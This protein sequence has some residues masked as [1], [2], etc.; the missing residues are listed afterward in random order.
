[1]TQ[2]P[3][4]GDTRALQAVAAQYFVNG[5]VVASY[6]PRLPEIR[7][8]LDVSLATIGL[9]ITAASLGGL[10]GSWLCSKL[11]ERFG[12][13]HLMIYGSLA[14]VVLLPCIALAPSIVALI[15][16]LAT[17]A[18]VDVL[19]DVSVNIQGST[20]SARR[21]TPVINRL[22]GLWSIGTVCGG[23]LAS[24]MAA[25]SMPLHWHLLGVSVMLTIG[26]AF[27]GGG[28]LTSDQ[29]AVESS[30]T[31]DK[32]SKSSTR[33]WI[34][35][36]L[37]ASAFVP[38]MI[39]SD[40]SPFRLRE[41]LSAGEGASGL[42]FVAFCAG[43][44]SGRMGGDWV[45]AKVGKAQLLNLATTVAAVG[46]FITCFIDWV[47]ASYLG[48]FIAGLGISVMFPTL[49]DTAARDKGRRGAALGAMTAGSRGAMLL[50]PLGIGWLANSPSLSVGYAI[51][52]VVPPCLLMVWFLTGKVS[53]TSVSKV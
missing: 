34:F 13:K 20:L 10:L 29:P 49:Y 53:G 2:G 21:A 6:I 26:L 38:E 51:A 45:V 41:D 7:E 30:S 19:V 47:P 48:L 16:V 42:A 33:L 35:T 46:L 40:W 37:G 32:Q 11:I 5:A 27:I 15:A 44:V 50:A 24:A 4:A 23:L 12:T 8:N 28:L 52:L 43:M 17:I 39:L 3:L 31:L 22:H 9:L 1:M 14:L 18:F 36:I 25:I